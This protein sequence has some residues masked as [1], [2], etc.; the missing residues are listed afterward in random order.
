[1]AEHF[2]QNTILHAGRLMHR[3]T[4][5]L[6]WAVMR[7]TTRSFPAA[8]FCKFERM[9]R[10]GGG[11]RETGATEVGRMEDVAQDGPFERGGYDC[12]K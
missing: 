10:E 1:M 3:Y 2:E 12:L 9:V 8:H 4:N 6:R 5:P 11:E 7:I